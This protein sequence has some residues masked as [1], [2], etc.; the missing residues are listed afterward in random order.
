VLEVGAWRKGTFY[1][2]ASV[3]Q[4]SNNTKWCFF[5]VYGLADH[6]RTEEFL[7]ELTQEVTS[8]L[9]PV[10]IGGDFNLIRVEKEKNNTNIHYPRVRWFNEAIATMALRELE[11]TWALFTWT[12]K[13]LRPTRCMLDRVLVAPAWEA[14]FLLCS[15][16]AIIRIGSDHTPSSC[17]VEK[18][19]GVCRLGFSSRLGGSMSHGL[20]AG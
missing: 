8:S 16:L 7:G 2:S 9:Y 5:L 13:L 19:P 6:R 1:I 4:R 14:A 10:V 15:L 18:R 11:R 3:L 20:G 17:P 12:N